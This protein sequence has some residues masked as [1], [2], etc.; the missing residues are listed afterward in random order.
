MQEDGDDAG[1]HGGEEP[2]TCQPLREESTGKGGKTME[3]G[4]EGGDRGSARGV[5]PMPLYVDG[6]G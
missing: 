2:S 5:F 3:L 6:L 4:Y 1:A